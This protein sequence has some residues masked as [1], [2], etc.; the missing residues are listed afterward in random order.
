MS[1]SSSYDYDVYL[2]SSGKVSDAVRSIAERLRA[3]GVAVWQWDVVGGDDI[4]ETIKES[5]ER[6]AC[7][8]VFVGADGLGPLQSQEV[9]VNI[10]DREERSGGRFRVIPVLLP[11]AVPDSLPPFLRDRYWVDFRKGLEDEEAFRLLVKSIQDALKSD[12]QATRGLRPG[13]GGGE[14]GKPKAAAESEEEASTHEQWQQI[15]QR[16]QQQRQQEELQRQQQQQQRRGGGPEPDASAPRALTVENFIDLHAATKKPFGREE[17]F[18]LRLAAEMAHSARRAVDSTLYLAALLS[19][20]TDTQGHAGYDLLRSLQYQFRNNPLPSNAAPKAH[21]V[22]LLGLSQEGVHSIPA[23]IHKR[24]EQ[25]EVSEELRAVADRAATL[26]VATASSRGTILVSHVIGAILAPSAGN[27]SS[28]AL[29]RL[30]SLHYNIRL[31]RAEFLSGI[32]ERLPERFEIWK[33]IFSHDP[34][35]EAAEVFEAL[36]PPVAH[37]GDAAAVEGAVGTAGVG[38]EPGDEAD[39]PEESVRES[40]RR[41]SV[42]DQPTAH[43]SLGFAPYVKAVAGCLADENTRPPL[44]L[45][46]EGEWGSGKS[47]FMMQLREELRALAAR[48]RREAMRRHVEEF[49][50]VAFTPPALRFL[51]SRPS[52]TRLRARRTLRRLRRMTR[53]VRCLAVEFNPWRHDKEDALWA[54]FALEFVRK[55]SREMPLG[56]RVR[57]HFKLLHRRF[58]WKDGWLVALRMFVLILIISF[59]L[60]AFVSLLTADGLRAW[61]ASVGGEDGGAGLFRV[62]QASGAAGYVAVILFFLSKF[63]EFVGNPFAF[64]LKRY[65]E[66]P[67]YEGR[68]AFIEQ[69]HEDFEKVVETYAGRDNKVFVFIDDLDR[70]DVPKAADLMQAINLMVSGEAPQLIFV[71]GMDREKVAAGL[72]VKNEKL[73][74][75]L[76]PRRRAADAQAAARNAQDV[77]F[78]IEYGYNFIEKFIQLPFSVPQPARMAVQDLL[79]YIAPLA[80]LTGDGGTSK[81]KDGARDAD[82]GGGAEAAREGSGGEEAR[83][84]EDGTGRVGEPADAAAQDKEREVRQAQEILAKASPSSRPQVA[85]AEADAVGAWRVGVGA[86]ERGPTFTLQDLGDSVGV[87]NIV[88]MA[89][90]A[91][92]YNPRR[93]KQYVNLFRLRAYIAYETGLLTSHARGRAAQLTLEQLG[94]FV[95]IGV[96]WPRLI[97]LLEEERTLLR[98]MQRLVIDLDYKSDS[99]TAYEWLGRKELESLLKFG[100]DGG[101]DPFDK[102]RPA[103]ARRYSL[104]NLDVDTLLQVSPRARPRAL[105]ATPDAAPASVSQTTIVNVTTAASEQELRAPGFDAGGEAEV[106]ESE[107]ALN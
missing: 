14:S 82:A 102:D 10:R 56:E 37:R 81:E 66:V 48:R 84:R 104:A 54:S 75:Y 20:S 79:D 63:R 72:A 43:D 39:A 96:R 105:A 23:E 8:A 31:L 99:Q 68:V 64:D 94:K 62:V 45:S 18:A 77:G 35:R 98:E 67:D 29:L 21:I 32:Q 51:T 47:S 86:A 107:A 58:K 28:N 50:A 46:I 60:V 16:R 83:P 24:A 40:V 80:R 19:A 57:A 22:L 49:R 12:A 92:D 30:E 5:L 25:V 95:A 106:S 2:S 76:A 26:A 85:R 4:S 61:A 100:C 103:D 42:S 71:I 9:L 36:T 38:Q 55:L 6:C 44:T 15:V 74:P 78:G 90:P 52:L 13:D 91:L 73:L 3:S 65:V 53:N 27:A 41:A 89:A 69:F 87:R 101:P 11:G 34:A 70:C 7:S 88:L 1:P 33:N 17:R 93:I 59:M 97:A